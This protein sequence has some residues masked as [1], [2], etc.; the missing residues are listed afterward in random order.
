[1]EKL[2]LPRNK[3]F[4][5]KQEY[6]YQV[7]RDAIMRCELVPGEKLVI[8]DIAGQLEVSTIPVREALQLLHSEDLVNYSPH[9]GAVV[10]PITKDSIIETFTIKEGLESAAM[11]VAMQKM[12]PEDLENL[13]EQL[14][15]MNT[16]LE[17]GK[18]GE[19]GHLNAKFHSSL[20][21]FAAMPVLKEMHTKVL[22]KWDRIRRYY[23]TEVLVNRH[24]QSQREHCDIVKA[25]G[26]KD[27]EKAEQLVR[28]HNR[29][30]LEDYMKHMN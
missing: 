30:A 16:V 4:K 11:G 17:S 23:F 14:A 18:T 15:E 22:D 10:A 9:A 25:V 21:D 7:L 13:R 3:P 5:T 24:D 6:V 26:D 19:W 12:T 28:L 8:S 27:R 20:V 29:N 2:S 1:M